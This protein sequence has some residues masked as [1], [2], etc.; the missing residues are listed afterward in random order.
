MQCMASQIF[1]LIS[2]PGEACRNKQEKVRKRVEDLGITKKS[3]APW[4]KIKVKRQTN[5]LA[6]EAKKLG[7][8]AGQ[9]KV[10]FRL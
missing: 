2:K 10:I 5:G 7:K 8:E 1:H 3:G 6:K 9:G 4:N